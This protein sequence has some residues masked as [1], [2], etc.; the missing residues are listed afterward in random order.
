[1]L[2]I[3]LLKYKINKYWNGS[4]HK[5]SLMAYAEA[6]TGQK[7]RGTEENQVETPSIKQK[8]WV[9]IRNRDTLS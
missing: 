9:E 3:Y 2:K 4:M 1:M 6:R 7:L 8:N 5:K